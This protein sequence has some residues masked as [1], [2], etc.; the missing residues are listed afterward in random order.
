MN[1][2]IAGLRAS[3]INDPELAIRLPKDWEDIYPMSG[4][5]SGMLYY[6]LVAKGTG[7]YHD[8][9]FT[10]IQE[11]DFNFP[12]F[13]QS[14][15]LLVDKHEVL[16]SSFHFSTFPQ[17]VQI[18]HH[19]AH[20][21]VLYDDISY[22]TAG[23]QESHIRGAMRRDLQ[24]PF[25]PTTPG[26]WRITVYRLGER[27][28]GALWMFHHAILDG[29]SVASLQTELAHVYQSL[30][31]D[32]Q[33]KPSPLK[34]TYRD[35]VADQLLV[36]Q[37]VATKSFWKQYLDGCVR[38]PLPLS[39]E[40]DPLAPVTVKAYSCKLD[41]DITEGL[42]QWAD[43]MQVHMKEICLAAFMQMLKL[44]TPGD[45]ITVGL[46]THGRPEVEDGD[47]LIGCFLNT[48]PVRQVFEKQYTPE[49]LVSLVSANARK[50]KAFDK[51]P[52][53]DIAEGMN[54]DAGITNPF[55]D[56]IF[57]YLDFHVY[58]QGAASGNAIPDKLV[59]IDETTTTN[60]LFD[61]TVTK[62]HTDYLLNVN[63]RT[64]IYSGSD[65][66]RVMNYFVSILR[67]FAS[68]PGVVLYNEQVLGYGEVETI[69][70]F[71]ADRPVDM[72]ALPIA[73]QFAQQARRA[74]HA[75]A[76]SDESGVM[77]YAELDNLSDQFAHYLVS[78]FAIRSEERIAVMLSPSI[79]FVAALLGI[80]KAG[81]AYVVIDRACP[82]ERAEYIIS[83][84]AARLVVTDHATLDTDVPIVPFEVK[85]IA[86]AQAA[87][88]RAT[89]Q[90]DHLVCITYTSGSQGTPLGVAFDHRALQTFTNSFREHY[91]LSS[92]DVFATHS[93]SSETIAHEIFPILLAGGKLAMFSPEIG[94]AGITKKLEQQKVSVFSASPDTLERMDTWTPASLRAVISSGDVAGNYSFPE[95]GRILVYNSYGALESLGLTTS[96]LLPGA[97][98]ST[99]KPAGQNRV[100]VIDRHHQ[101][102]PIGAC[103]Q[104][105]IA[106]KHLAR[107]YWKA[108][109]LTELKFVASPFDRTERLYLTGDIGRWT[110]SGTL[111]LTGR[112]DAQTK[113][114]GVRVAPEEATQ[115][116]KSHLA[117]ED[118]I[119]MMNTTPHERYLAAYYTG[120]QDLSV[121]ELKQYLAFK[122]PHYLVPGK[123]MWLEKIPLTASGKPDLRALANLTGI[124]REIV[125]PGDKTEE[126]LVQLWAASMCVEPGTVSVLDN[127]FE[128]GLQSLKATSLIFKIRHVF[129]R[130]VSLMDIFQAPT[131]RSLADK[132]KDV[133]IAA[134]QDDGMVKLSYSD[135][136]AR[137]LFFIHD[138]TG[139][140]TAYLE[141]SRLLKGYNCWGLRSKTLQYSGPVGLSIQDLAAH[142]I[143]AMRVVQPEGPYSVAGWSLGGIIAHEIVC[144]LESQ[145]E[146]VKVLLMMDTYIPSLEKSGSPVHFT[147]ERERGLID[148][149]VPGA[150]NIIIDQSGDLE[151]LWKQALGVL[152]HEASAV[153]RLKNMIPADMRSILP[154]INKMEPATIVMYGNTIRSLVAAAARYHTYQQ[155]DAPVYFIQAR[156]TGL[157][158]NIHESGVG[159]GSLIVTEVSGNHYTMLMQ[160]HVSTLANVIEEKVLRQEKESLQE[161]RR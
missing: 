154:D 109:R 95:S 30:K 68:Q 133:Q 132:L 8:Q 117:I 86:H 124:S 43:A 77:T 12:L 3:V 155:P 140:V 83:H 34:S 28:L 119:V 127:F 138:G 2:E 73:M 78:R 92:G 80:V 104:I 27:T 88:R 93:V 32:A 56:I 20:D 35:Y 5:V 110:P 62:W 106:S 18:V 17:P 75:A 160:P 23:G 97:A 107:G 38:T 10:V 63:Y 47:K 6:D 65:I 103:G 143:D 60:T 89:I 128:M 94:K 122:L 24:Q 147:V 115:Q 71:N 59:S 21:T 61:F 125:K 148:L 64:N 130:D 46:V 4:I 151:H 51:L 76:V 112:M 111:E 84:S 146:T 69:K 50:V 22:L 16:R 149:I 79:N 105:A 118:V 53:A 29:W 126:Q 66:A 159:A 96:G 42:S 101:L 102:V 74:P 41:R 116:L 49:A 98:R 44:T 145:G 99:G 25:E 135:D 52:L 85:A 26:L 81:A 156:E 113:I 141:L 48:V 45:D 36:K 120:E 11:A 57:N 123:F 152:R 137:N 90:P 129:G 82:A 15:M 131:I 70:S 150:D 158:M 19:T 37:D 9:L 7:I 161:T 67:A 14:F 144:Q 1:A 142:Y 72:P 40:I 87:V 100:Y 157:P 121:A 108:D 54:H 139:E 33:F 58:G 39:P 153:Q 136:T 91:A 55:F 13:K 114:H 134:D 31:R